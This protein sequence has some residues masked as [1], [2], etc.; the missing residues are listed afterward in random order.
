MSLPHDSRRLGPSRSRLA[1][2]PGLPGA[3]VA[4][5]AFLAPSCAWS[6]EQETARESPIPKIPEDQLP[7]QTRPKPDAEKDRYV[8][9][10]VFV[11][12]EERIQPKG[13]TLA[14]A[15]PRVVESYLKG[16]LQRAGFPIA[17]SAEKASLLLE[18]TVDLRFHSELVAFGRDVG[19]KYRGQGSFLLRDTHGNDR[20]SFEIPEVFRESVKSEESAALQ[21]RRYMAKVAWD[22]LYHRKTALSD[23]KVEALINALT[24]EGGAESLEREGHVDRV[25]STEG[26]IDALADAGFP[27]VPYLLEALRDDRPVR[28]PSSYPGLAD[29]GA[30]SL[31]VY[32]IADKALEEIFQKVSRLSLDTEYEPRMRVVAG[33][34]N[35]WKRFCPPF[36]EFSRQQDEARRRAAEQRESQ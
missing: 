15:E 14:A 20:G 16:Y 33:W 4:L 18:G 22:N 34:E 7:P 30:A 5:L 24:I 36:A 21:T 28:M 19:W 12:V 31:R 17:E 10:P 13:G 3:F 1:A 25:E 32:H 27:A 8:R 23:P 35:E 9:D 26:V 29:G 6:A 11:W 2:P